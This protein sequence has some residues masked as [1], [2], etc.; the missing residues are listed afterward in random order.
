MEELS[1]AAGLMVGLMWMVTPMLSIMAI[2]FV[3]VLLWRGT[4]AV[5]RI[6][7]SLERGG[8]APDGNAGITT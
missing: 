2:A 7:A 4:R 6:A 1:T 3:I 8:A 5:E